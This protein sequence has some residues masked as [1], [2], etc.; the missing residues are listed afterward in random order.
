MF[1]PTKLLLIAAGLA[2]AGAAQAQS[3]GASPA[4]LPEARSPSPELLE[5]TRDRYIF[6]FKEEAIGQSEVRAEARAM[7]GQAGGR[8]DYVYEHSIRGFAARMPAQAAEALA[9]DPAIAYYEPDG[10][11]HAMQSGQTTDWGVERVNGP[12]DGSDLGLYAF[13]L[14]TGVDFEHDDLTMADSLHRNFAADGSSA[15][16]LNG[17]GTHVAGIL[18]ARDNGIDTVGVAAGAS[19][20]S[21]RVLDES[22]SGSYADIIAGIDHVAEVGLEGEVANLSIGGP[23]SDSVDDAV[24]NAASQGIFF[25]VAA[26]NDTQD[27]SNVSPAGAGTCDNVYTIS[28]HDIDDELASFSNFGNPPISCADPGVEILSLNLGGGTRTLSGTSMASPHAAGI[29]LVSGG[30]LYDGGDV[31]WDRDSNPDPICVLN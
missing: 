26:G 4:H 6:V 12:A 22:G 16:D 13:V 19:V 21:V 2:L 14:D 7:A 29:L 17:H 23:S 30:T 10:I 18:A 24:C 8:V 28:A 15:Q 31:S 5:R 20:V 3:S 11:A 27:A 25:A 9:R 1:Y